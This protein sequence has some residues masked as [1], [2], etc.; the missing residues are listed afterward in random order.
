MK[1]QNHA[2]IGAGRERGERPRGSSPHTTGGTVSLGLDKGR[3]AETRLCT[4]GEVGVPTEGDCGSLLLL[5]DCTGLL[6]TRERDAHGKFDGVDLDRCTVVGKQLQQHLYDGNRRN[7]I[8]KFKETYGGLA[9]TGVVVVYCTPLVPE[10]TGSV[11]DIGEGES[12]EAVADDLDAPELEEL[13]DL[14]NSMK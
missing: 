12:D 7:R 10:D 11:M 3:N 4:N 9:S 14:K 13:P 2:I 5:G 6:Y 8:I 1:E